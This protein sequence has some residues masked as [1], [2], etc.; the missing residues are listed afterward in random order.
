[1]NISFTLEQIRFI[2]ESLDIEDPDDALDRFMTIIQE[3]RVD[4]DRV[5]TYLNKLMKKDHPK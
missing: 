1:M 2:M 3:E 4:P 5:H